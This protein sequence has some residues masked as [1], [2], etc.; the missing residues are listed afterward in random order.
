MTQDGAGSRTVRDATLDLL[1]QLGLTTIFSNPSHTEMKLFD[2]WPDDFKFITGLHESSVVGMADGYA[3]AT[4]KP[5]L[6]IING[7]PGLGNA[8]GSVYTAASAHTPMVILGGQQA[9][10]LLLGEP[11]LNATEAP[12]LPRPYIKWSGE[13][14][15]PQDIPALIEKAYHIAA[16]APAGPVFV[17]VPED[18]WVRPASPTPLKPRTVRSAVV[19]DPAVISEIAEALNGAERPALVAGPGV[20]IGGA[21]TE[22]VRLAERLNATVYGS[23][24]WP[25]GSFPETHPLFGGVLAPLPELINQRLAEHDVVVVLGS[26]TFTLF[27][28]ADLFST[29]P[30]PLDQSDQPRLPEGTRVIHVTDDPEAAAWS[31][32]D[33]AVVCPPAQAVR[34]LVPLAV[35]RE[36]AAAP[37]VQRA[38]VAVPEPST[39]LSQAY[40]F[41]QL[42]QVLP[43]DAQ[44]FE[45]LPIAR[46]DFHEQLPLG[47]QNGYFA[48]ASGALG[49]PFA[50]GVGYAVARPDQRVVVVTGEGS[51]QY[52]LHALWTAARYNLPVTFVIPN[53][54]GYLSLKYYLDEAGQNAWQ[55]GWDLSGVDMAQLARGFGCPAERIETPEQLQA[56]LKTAM[57][58]DGPMLLDVVVADPGLFRL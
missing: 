40:L 25:R 51:A 49:F 9:R 57:S 37:V 12:S 42:A 33:S 21:R 10:K 36:R 16:Q 6:V 29:A 50:G 18:D 53:N 28:T 44:V 15:R 41:H 7:G 54:S 43:E 17:A 32:A 38:E 3:Q 11:F 24:V 22:L 47:P 45:E 39:P 48:T 56:A 2:E 55:E 27:T 8:M 26:P 31:L 30:A 19:P 46:A 58:T 14:A 35:Q 13:P 20:E 5:S 23:P 52:T 1:R 4:G 34:D